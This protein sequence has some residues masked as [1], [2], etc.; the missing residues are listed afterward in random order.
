MRLC[1]HTITKGREKV[2]ERTLHEKTLLD[3]IFAPIEEKKHSVKC[4]ECSWKGR[5]ARSLGVCPKCGAAIIWD[6]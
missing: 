6:L 1:N 4:T 3:A 5:R 2:M